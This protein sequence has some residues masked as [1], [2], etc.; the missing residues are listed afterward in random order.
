MKFLLSLTIVVFL[1]NFTSC[2]SGGSSKSGNK[3]DANNSNTDNPNRLPQNVA[4]GNTYAI[5]KDSLCSYSDEQISQS[6]EKQ[7][8]STNSSEARLVLASNNTYILTLNFQIPGQE[9]C[10]AKW[11]LTPTNHRSNATFF[12]FEV[13]PNN[14][15][16]TKTG[17]CHLFN[18]DESA[19]EAVAVVEGNFSQNKQILRFTSVEKSEGQNEKECTVYHRLKLPS[20]PP[21]NGDSN[22]PTNNDPSNGDDNEDDDQISLWTVNEKSK[23]LQDCFTGKTY[24]ASFYSQPQSIDHIILCSCVTEL[25]SQ[26]IPYSQ[27]ATNRRQFDLQQAALCKI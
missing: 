13:K 15:R 20:N 25:L 8:L 6:Y 7:I 2:G 23:E 5:V 22:P 19:L 4:D 1:F 24:L 27:Y 16:F 21:T 9:S 3:P 11:T 26:K 14:V 18:V 12:S 17:A 10:E